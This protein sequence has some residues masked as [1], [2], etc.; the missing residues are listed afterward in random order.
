MMLPLPHPLRALIALSAVLTAAFG[1]TT[2]AASEPVSAGLQR[3]S[4]DTAANEKIDVAIWYPTAILARE[5][6]FGPF[7]MT[8]A[9]DAPILLSAAAE[10]M[11][12]PLIIISHGTGGN[13]FTH[14]ELA[15]ALASAGYIVAA[16]THPGDN[17]R[18]RSLVASPKYF[19]ERPRQVSRVIDALLADAVWRTHIDATR[20]GFLGHSAGGFTGLALAGATP[21]I[22]ATVRHCAANYDDDGW[23]C[24]VSGSK[25]KAIANAAQADYMPTVPSS[26]D[27]R[28]RAAVLLAPIGV[29]FSEAELKKITI[30][31]R[32]VVAGRD[33]V[34][35]P[36]F[37]AEFVAR[38]VANAEVIVNAEGGHFM[39]VSRLNINP[40][41]SSGAEINQDPKGFDRAAAIR[42][43]AKTLPAWFDKALQR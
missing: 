14:H 35:T 19:S 28:I 37:H 33:D 10:A 30:P 25:E 5:Q 43:A 22:A 29:F 20:I 1:L 8:V 38:C 23:F 11:P 2:L 6:S 3:V 21:S 40:A 4:L 31:T 15:S 32:V 18:D 39:L 26:R 24:R 9:L 13:N 42:D 34:L 12:R 36:R 41:A 17:V 7:T 27:A 16:L